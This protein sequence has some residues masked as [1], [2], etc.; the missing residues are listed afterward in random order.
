MSAQGYSP[1]RAQI[2]QILAGRTQA[3]RILNAREVSDLLTCWPVPP[4]RTIR[5]YMEQVRIKAEASAKQQSS[6]GHGG[7]SAAP[8]A[9]AA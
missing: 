7:Q 5:R 8:A 4:L 2:A 1:A 3:R 9:R 6:S